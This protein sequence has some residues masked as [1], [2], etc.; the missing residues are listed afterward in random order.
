MGARS[1]GSRGGA[2]RVGGRADGRGR[3]AVP[4]PDPVVGGDPALSVEE[5]PPAN[6]GP[7]GPSGPFP[8]VEALD[9]VGRAIASLPKAAMFELRDRG[10]GS[11]FEMLA[12]ALISARTRDETTLPVSLRLFAR[13]PTPE[14][15]A[16]MPPAELLGLLAGVTFAE[17]KARD[18]RELSARI[19]VEHGGAVPDSVEGLVSFRGVGPKI[20]A[21]VLGLGYGRP[22]ISV[23]VHVHRIVHRWGLVAGA[24]P[25]R[26]ATAL[27]AVVPRDR[28]I[29]VN[30]RL[31]P[32]GKAICT[33]GRPRCSGCPL[34][35]ICPRIG[36]DRPR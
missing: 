30:E 32:F 17:T 13:A 29:Q 28:W 11:P 24:D 12:A 27:E 33:A 10:H 14:Q 6:P 7:D 5:D 4:R 1:L 23:D 35:P 19:V 15:V 3:R 22:A 21:L 31:V 18:L 26:T 20:A 25:P 9:R 8:V 16:A 36:V 34:R 2:G